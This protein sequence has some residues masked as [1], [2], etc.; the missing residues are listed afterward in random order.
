MRGRSIGFSGRHV[1]VSP[2]FLDY[3]QTAVGTVIESGDDILD[4]TFDTA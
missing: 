4:R 3:L 1:G 2:C